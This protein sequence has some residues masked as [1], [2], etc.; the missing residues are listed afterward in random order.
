MLPQ[1]LLI[2]GPV[3]MDEELL[4]LLGGQAVPHYG[5][6]WAALY[7][8]TVAN[9]RALFRTDG[10]VYPIV[11]SGSTGLDAT[12]GSMLAPGQ[13]L[14]LVRNGYFGDHLHAIAVA[15]GIE[16]LSIEAPWGRAVDPEAVRA[17]LDAAEPVHALALVH[18]ETSTGALNPLRTIAALGKE[19]G[20]PVIVDAVTALGGVELCMDAWG[21]DVC[22][23][24]P[25]KALAAPA[26]LGLVAVARSAWAYMDSHPVGPRGWYQD[27]R[28]WRHYGEQSPAFHPQPATMPTG[29]LAALHFQT[30]RILEQG[31]EHYIARHARAS[32]RFRDGA[33]VA[34]FELLVPEAE[35][36]PQLSAVV[37]PAWVSADVALAA[38]RE[39][40]NL[41][42]GSG[43][44]ELRGRIIR[45]G[46]MGKAASDEYVDAALRALADVL[47]P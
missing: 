37:L 18:A 2:P 21:V 7:H 45:I 10:D 39:Q 27:L 23:S 36:T 43:L 11:G 29:T 13:R 1:R 20:L 38:L 12:L 19:R 5:P 9:L 35:A 17:A 31:L 26:G 16:V 32:R 47:R 46:H 34:G 30:R 42:A 25:Q 4:K 44:G 14:A 8:E 24:A 22:V 41:V 3:D 40:H 28:T 15:N 33:K 6:A